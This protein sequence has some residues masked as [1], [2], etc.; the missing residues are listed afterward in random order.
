M[1]WAFGASS[2]KYSIN[3]TERNRFSVNFHSESFT[4]RRKNSVIEGICK[5]MEFSLSVDD[6]DIV[7]KSKYKCTVR[8]SVRNFEGVTFNY[9]TKVTKL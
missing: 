4:G 8:S 1:Y 7:G 6:G 9:Q 5:A 3:R 2:V